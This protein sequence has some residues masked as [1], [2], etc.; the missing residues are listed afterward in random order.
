MGKYFR[1]RSGL[2]LVLAS[3]AAAGAG[4][5]A[6]ACTGITVRARDGAIIFARTLEF[7]VDLQSSVI[8][9]PRGKEFAGG[10]NMGSSAPM[11]LECRSLWMD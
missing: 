5:H 1:L 7:G 4:L 10:R 2:S 9:I 11:R 3:C 6:W 8:V